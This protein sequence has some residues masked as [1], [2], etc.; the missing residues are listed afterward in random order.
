[1]ASVLEML[2]S[3][4]ASET[5]Q[6]STQV[7]LDPREPNDPR[8]LCF[9]VFQND[10]LVFFGKKVQLDGL[11]E[12]R[13]SGLI[14]FNG[15]ALIAHIK[16]TMGCIEGAQLAPGVTFVGEDVILYDYISHP[17][18]ESLGRGT[19]NIEALFRSSVEGL[20]ALHSK[21]VSHLDAHWENMFF[22]GVARRPL[23][24][25]F[26]RVLDEDAVPGCSSEA[27]DFFRLFSSLFLTPSLNMECDGHQRQ[28]ADLFWE[29][30]TEGEKEAVSRIG[31]SEVKVLN[32]KIHKR[33]SLQR[34]LDQLKVV[35]GSSFK[36]AAR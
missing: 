28:L 7:L 15:R 23:F 22:P 14:L 34:A 31:A 13:K 9:R 27:V 26:D 24:I 32:P 2:S 5:K 25:D 3:Q 19:N 33:Q 21:G 12:I 20:R 16:K 35:S 30:L 4:I 6:P 17:T 18:F 29:Q 36:W 8:V 11:E 1:M 10:Q